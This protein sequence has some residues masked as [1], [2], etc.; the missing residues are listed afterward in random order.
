MIRKKRFYRFKLISLFYVSRAGF[1]AANV[2][3]CCC[4]LV[5][6]CPQ[7]NPEDQLGHVQPGPHSHLHPALPGLHWV[8][9]LLQGFVLA[10]YKVLLFFFSVN[11]SFNFSMCVYSN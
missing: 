7:S 3:V 10:V 4:Y 2:K 9:L 6:R 11:D 8:R 5:E 1:L